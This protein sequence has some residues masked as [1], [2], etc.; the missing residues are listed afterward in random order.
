MGSTAGVNNEAASSMM[1]K[2]WDSAMALTPQDDEEETRR[3]YST[4]LRFCVC[5]CV[6]IYMISLGLVSHIL[7]V[8]SQ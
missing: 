4:L 3:L 2:F 6:Y 7:L 5:V 8:A 1:Q